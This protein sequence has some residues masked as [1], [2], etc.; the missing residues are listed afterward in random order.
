MKKMILGLLIG[1][2]MSIGAF[3]FEKQWYD[4]GYHIQTIDN[5]YNMMQSIVGVIE[6]LEG[7]EL[8]KA[9]LATLVL[10]ANIKTSGAE[11][12]SYLVE[13]KSDMRKIMSEGYYVNLVIVTGKFEN[14][15][16]DNFKSVMG[17]YNIYSDDLDKEMDASTDADAAYSAML[18]S[19]ITG[20]IERDDYVYE[21]EIL[22]NEVWEDSL[23]KLGD[24][25][26]S[27]SQMKMLKSV[28]NDV[29]DFKRMD[30]DI[31]KTKLIRSATSFHNAVSS[32]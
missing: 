31:N 8:Q 21:N 4:Y 15:T 32:I 2:F 3:G 22:T 17:D 1:V 29:R 26:L 14:M 27:N 12:H 25:Y 7:E 6:V 24:R 16:I 18:G 23:V 20:I 10:L 19:A 28:S 30:S 13:N 11:L 9:F 5:N